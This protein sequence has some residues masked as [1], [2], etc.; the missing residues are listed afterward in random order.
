MK[1]DGASGQ[2]R[3][4]ARNGQALVELALLLPLYLALLVTLLWFASFGL[5]RLSA[6]E[7]ARW[8]A[9]RKPPWRGAE[10]A[11]AGRRIA[12][13]PETRSV[14]LSCDPHLSGGAG[15]VFQGLLA[16]REGSVTVR[17][18]P[19]PYPH[20]GRREIEG[21]ARFVFDPV[22]P[23]SSWGERLARVL[24]VREPPPPPHVR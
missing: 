19:L 12:G 11:P 2:A 6:E 4:R 5:S 22:A 14:R 17:T 1:R 16:T 3:L 10:E 18:A 13:L 8:A 21:I 15:G 9:W 23:A 20:P 7:G 24:G